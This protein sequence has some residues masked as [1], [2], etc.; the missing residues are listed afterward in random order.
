MN[1]FSDGISI[2][3]PLGCFLSQCPCIEE[4]GDVN[5]I[6]HLVKKK[7]SLSNRHKTS[8]SAIRYNNHFLF[9]SPQLLNSYF[10]ANPSDKQWDQTVFVQGL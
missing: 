1:K 3:S 7:S 9:P 4:G 6:A 2:P 10:V 5:T 8:C